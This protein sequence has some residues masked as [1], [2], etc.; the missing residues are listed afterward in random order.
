MKTFILLRSSFIQLADTVTRM[1][2]KLPN[3]W[4]VETKKEI[5][6]KKM[7]QGQKMSEG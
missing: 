1:L 4:Q 5:D 2:E 7:N 6:S 3:D